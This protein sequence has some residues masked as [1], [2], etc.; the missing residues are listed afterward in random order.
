[1][2]KSILVALT[3]A[4]VLS[5]STLTAFAAGSPTTVDAVQAAAEGQTTSTGI[6][7]VASAD[8]L[9]QAT[10]VSEGYKAS[11]V[12]D[13]TVQS[14]VVAVQNQILN[15]IAEIGNLLGDSKLAA[16]ATDPSSKVTATIRSLVN[17][18]PTTATK[19]ADGLYEVTV[20][21][22][23]LG[24]GDAIVLHY[25]GT[26]WEVIAPTNVSGKNVTFKTATLSPVAVVEVNSGANT[27]ATSPK[28]GETLPVAMMVVVLGIA[29]AAVCTKKIFA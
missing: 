8:A 12:S 21:A 24:N 11:A 17:I 5:M 23:Y 25:N 19:G 7:A 16:E 27:V 13:T 20:T 6:E 10:A 9:A 26:A 29:G 2:K 1:M 3:A 22:A 28:T 18:D 15:K 4:M 14:A